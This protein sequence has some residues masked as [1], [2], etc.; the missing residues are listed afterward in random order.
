MAIW[1]GKSQ[2]KSTGGRLHAAAKKRKFEIGREAVLTTIGEHKR[3]TVRIRGG[4]DRV[5]VIMAKTVIV[6]DPKT[7]KSK[8]AELQTVTG[9]PANP[10]YIRRNIVTKGAIV[11]TS[12]G[13]ARVTSRPGQDGTINAVLIE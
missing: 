5:R 3:K 2:R 11:K 8:K 13:N 7:G 12:A 6:T 9:N 10:N 1:Q 4:H